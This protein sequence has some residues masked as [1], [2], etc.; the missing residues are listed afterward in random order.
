MVPLAKNWSGVEM[1]RQSFKCHGAIAVA[2]A[3]FVVSGCAAPTAVE[4]G[5][6]EPTQ[7]HYDGPVFDPHIHVFFDEA[8]A[9]SVHPTNEVTP[10]AVEALLA[11]SRVRAGLMVM[12]TGS[13]EEC[14][15]DNDRI[16]ALAQKIPGAFPIGSVNPHHADA[17]LA[18]LDRMVEAG[19][20]WI[21][22][23]PNTQ[24]FDVSDPMIAR[25][26]KRAGELGV[27]V[28]FDA[29]A[30]LDA[31]QIGKFILLAITNPKTDIVLAHMG[32]PRFDELSFLD[33]FEMYP[34]WQRNIWLDISYTLP[35]F[36]SSPKKDL[37]VW[38]MRTV[39]MDRVLFA[40]DYPALTPDETIQAVRS[41][42]LTLDEETAIFHTNTLSLLEK[43]ARARESRAKAA[44]PA[45]EVD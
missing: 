25:I 12:A 37:L 2:A 19:V 3:L 34:W 33:A 39:G 4:K 30:V 26:V 45:P 18:E 10:A 35:L 29:S 15:A 21:K 31:G 11:G 41:L 38:T 22:L 17:A 5:S 7:R 24:R 8:V 6:G 32:G 44:S 1:K 27:P 42:N 14:T 9:K 43:E 13:P 20:R 28:T 40:S 23:H 36:A 16:V